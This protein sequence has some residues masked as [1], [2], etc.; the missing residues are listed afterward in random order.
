MNLKTAEWFR[1]R[2]AEAFGPP[3]VPRADAVETLVLTIL[4]QNTTDANRDR[5]YESLLLRFGTLDR[6]ARAGEAEIAEAVR[7]AGL[8]A[9]K[10]AA[11][12]TAL[13]RILAES[14]ALDLAFLSQRTQEDAF[15]W[16]CASRGVGPKT[17][18]IVL[19]FSFGM[20]VFPVDTHIRRVL[21]RIGI[22]PASGDAFRDANALLPRD[23]EL[24]LDL[25]L[26][27]IQLGR[28]LCRP[29]RPSCASCLI[30]TRCEHGRAARVEP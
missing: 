13:R 28:T 18:S 15:S 21:R 1:S 29:R 11:I 26:L 4:S 12:R 22:I 16:L 14:G 6:V 9:Q 27:L 24:L 30:V 8:Q 25:H 20:P 2:L 3:E 23:A 17:A 10:A 5:A 7:V 19:L